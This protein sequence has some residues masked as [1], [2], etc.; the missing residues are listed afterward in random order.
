MQNKLKTHLITTELFL[1]GSSFYR[2]I[3]LTV[4]IVLPLAIL[5]ITNLFE[6]APA[7]ALGTFLNAPSDV[8]GSLRRKINGILI[9]ILLTLLVSFIVF[10]TKPYFI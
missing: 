10:V 7:I 6:F 4:A 9:S 8:P 5:N 2:G 1:K 3:V